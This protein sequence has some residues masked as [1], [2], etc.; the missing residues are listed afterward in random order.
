MPVCCVPVVCVCTCSRA[1]CQRA[2]IKICLRLWHH[3]SVRDRQNKGVRGSNSCTELLTFHIIQ[4]TFLS[5]R[6]CHTL[7]SIQRLY[8]CLRTFKTYNCTYK[9]IYGIGYIFWL[10][11]EVTLQFLKHLCEVWSYSFFKLI[12]SKRKVKY[13]TPYAIFSLTTEWQYLP[14]TQSFPSQEVCSRAHAT[15]QRLREIWDARFNFS[16]LQDHRAFS[17]VNK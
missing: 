2:H 15:A 4:S 10:F 13:N 1:F 9:V 3:N 7:L 17:A 6:L 16:L 8:V 5:C 12:F 11:K 14:L